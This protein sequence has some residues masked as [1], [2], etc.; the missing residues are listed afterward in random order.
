MEINITKG[1][2]DCLLIILF[3]FVLLP[4]MAFGGGPVEEEE[5]WR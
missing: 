2:I 3:N 1:D 4:W 5:E